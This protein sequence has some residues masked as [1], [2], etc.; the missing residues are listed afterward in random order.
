MCTPL[1]THTF[2]VKLTSTPLILVSSLLVHACT[3]LVLM[4]HFQVYKLKKLIKSKP[5]MSYTHFE[6]ICLERSC[7]HSNRT[8]VL[9]L[10]LVWISIGLLT[11]ADQIISGSGGS[12]LCGETFHNNNPLLFH[13]HTHSTK[14]I[15]ARQLHF[16]YFQSSKLVQ[17]LLGV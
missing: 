13:K 14:M 3:P 8:L 2:I 4:C 12:P 10:V 1:L 5:L 15:N 17:H 16:Y 7:K 6:Y 9:Y 11:Y